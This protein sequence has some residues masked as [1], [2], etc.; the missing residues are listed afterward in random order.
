MPDGRFTG[1]SGVTSMGRL[2]RYSNDPRW[3]LALGSTLL[4]IGVSV[5]YIFSIQ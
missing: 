1:E 3:L 5:I 4:I 2:N